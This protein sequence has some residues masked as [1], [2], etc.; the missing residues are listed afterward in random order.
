V[1]RPQDLSESVVDLSFRLLAA[2]ALGALSVLARPASAVGA[3]G[4]P[5]RP[6]AVLPAM[7]PAPQAR[8]QGEVSFEYFQERL[9]NL[10]RWLRHPVW[11]DVWQPDAGRDFRPYFYGYWQYTSDYGWLWVSNEPYGDIVYHYGR[12]VYDPNYGWLWAP[13][14][15]WGPSWVAWRETDGYIGWFP[16]PPGYQDFSL[17]PIV[18]PFVPSYAPNDLYGYQYF[19]GNNFAQDAFAGLWVFVPS[20]HFGRS[21]HRPYVTD[22]GRV[23][24]LYHRSHDRTHYMHDRDRDRIVDRSIDKDALER[25][26]NRYFGA[27]TGAQ[28]MRRDTPVTS[29]TEGQEIFRRDW[30]RA[31]NRDSARGPIDAGPGLVGLPANPGTG[32]SGQ[33]GPAGQGQPAPGRGLGNLGRRFGVP[34]GAQF[35]VNP[36][37]GAGDFNNTSPGDSNRRERGRFALPLNPPTPLGATGVPASPNIP[38]TDVLMGAQNPSAPGTVPRALP[39]T[40]PTSANI[41]L[42]RLFGGARMRGFDVGATPPSLRVPSVPTVPNVATVAPAPVVPQVRALPPAFGAQQGPIVPPAPMAQAPASPSAA[43]PQISA[44]SPQNPGVRTGRF[45]GGLTEPHRSQ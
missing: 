21:D 24:D 45:L 14:Y 7:P 10:G 26:T 12:W 29:V 34:P 35:G 18:P 23:R 15:V 5:P 6:P 22:K 41:A 9:S 4:P 1:S 2:V 25:Q 3:P 32:N 28:F 20:L 16:M 38:S 27:Q 42:G 40:G 19:Y 43:V 8:P 17:G 11:G 31:R 33:D 36:P 13:G 37:G 39:Q 30:E 44:P